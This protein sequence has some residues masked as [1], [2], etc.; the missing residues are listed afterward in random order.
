MSPPDPWL[1]FPEGALDAVEVTDGQARVLDD[2]RVR[3]DL[4]GPLVRVATF[5]A[6]GRKATAQALIRSLAHEVGIEEASIHELYRA[7]GRGEVEGFTVPAMNL[8]TMTYDMARA[9]FRAAEREDVGALVFEIARSEIG[10]TGQ[11]PAEYASAVLGAAIRE[12]HRGPVFL[13]GDHF[14]F[15]PEAVAEDADAEQARIDDLAEEAIEAGFYNIDVDASTLV[16]LDEADVTDQQRPNVD[17]TLTTLA[18]IRSLEPVTVSVGGEVGEV[19]LET[20]TEPELRVF[21][22]QLDDG[23]QQ[24]GLEGI[25]KASVQTGTQHGGV[26]LP[27]GSLA[28]ADVDVE[29]VRRL[30]RLAREHGLAGCVQHGASTLRDELFARFREAGAAEIHLATAFL[31]LVLDHEAFPGE[32]TRRIEEHLDEHLADRR[33]PEATDEQFVYRHRKRAMGALKE[34]MWRVAEDRKQAIFTDLEERFS[35]LFDELGVTGT[36]DTVDTYVAPDPVEPTV[37]GAWRADLAGR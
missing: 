9:A 33:K 25:S 13:Q 31:N 5:A 32:L 20:T 21:L 7:R 3:E 19:G 22:E 6:G 30:S 29:A 37:P 23:C 11:S 15:D 2:K 14:Q 12:G 17:R 28:E 16:D 24:R 8:R 35:F 36:T 27:D 10:Y 4:V 1:R 26:V 18:R 34:P